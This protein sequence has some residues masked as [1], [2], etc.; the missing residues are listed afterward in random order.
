MKHFYIILFLLL[1][2]MLFS[3]T[4][5]KADGA[6]FT[7]FPVQALRSDFFTLKN[8]CFNKLIPDTQGEV[9][10]VEFQLENELDLD[11]EFYIF[12]IATYEKSYK[13]TSS[14]ERPSLDDTDEIKLLTPYPNDISNFEYSIK[15]EKGTESKVL[16]KYPKN[17]KAG[18][19][20]ETG[21][22]YLLRD[23]M[24][25]RSRHLSKYGKKFRY[26]NEILILIFDNE[27]KLVYRQI[28]KVKEKRR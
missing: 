20:P 21:K 15:D 26:Y 16:V 23:Y 27:E 17:I 3:Q 8:L 22:M 24:T 19:N 12:V 28:Y 9:L 6:D 5:K 13:T 2:V 14:F 18:I 11:Q 25:F 1:P 7:S 10:E 4:E